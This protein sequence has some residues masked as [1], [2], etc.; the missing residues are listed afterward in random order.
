M[1]ATFK[2]SASAIL[3]FMAHDTTRPLQL[4]RPPIAPIAG[5]RITQ[6]STLRLLWEPD[7]RKTFDHI[8][9]ATLITTPK[10]GWPKSTWKGSR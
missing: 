1:L 9:M 8:V 2:F 7:A 3:A 6:C 4:D 10:G 5:K